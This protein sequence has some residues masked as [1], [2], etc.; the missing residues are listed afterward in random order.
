MKYWAF[1]LSWVISI[2]KKLR[3]KYFK[4]KFLKGS[5]TRNK[6]N[7]LQNNVLLIKR[8]LFPFKSF[9]FNF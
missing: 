7:N 4:F 5:C 3:D 6:F 1:N 8:R 2:G 9:I